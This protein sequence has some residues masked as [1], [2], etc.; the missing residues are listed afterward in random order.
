M[1]IALTG[2]HGLIA[3]HLMPVLESRGHQ[4]LR[5]VRASPATTGPGELAWDPER[6][7]LDVESLA[8]VGAAVHLAG[9]GIFGRRWNEGYKAEVL[10]SRVKGTHLLARSLA[11]LDPPPA[12]LLSGSAV[13]FYGDRGDEDLDEESPPGE[14]FLAD[15]CQRWEAATEPAAAAG[16]RTVFLRTGIV[17]AAGGGALKAV[18]PM[19]RLGL[20]AKLGSGQQ[21]MSWIAVQ[22]HVDAIAHALE[23]ASLSGPLNMVAPNPVTNA[24]Y[25]RTLARV[26]RRPAVLRVP[27]PVLRTVMGKEMATELF[28]S[29]QR[30]RPELLLQSG[31]RFAHPDLQGALADLLRR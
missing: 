20:G 16:V 7:L 10:E 9:A 15:L 4:V 1:K 3:R 19:F 11:R 6:G 26:L 24:D 14:G 13:G 30:A 23:T 31:F 2:S 18:L 22:D 17:L 25:T 21:W 8:G 29:G 12:V 28:L 5:V 27:A